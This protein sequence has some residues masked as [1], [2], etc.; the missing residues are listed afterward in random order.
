MDDTFG[1]DR[2]ADWRCEDLR[3]GDDNL[4]IDQFLVKFRILSVLVRGR[5][6]SVSL[7]LKPFADSE[8]VFRCAQKFRDVLGVLLAIVEDEEYFDLHPADTMND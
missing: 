8:F 5:H 4:S 7:V 3:C 2:L 1:A 6:Q